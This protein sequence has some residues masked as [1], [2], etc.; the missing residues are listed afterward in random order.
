MLKLETLPKPLSVAGRK[1]ACLWNLCPF[2]CG[3]SHVTV[4][5]S[6]SQTACFSWATEDLSGQDRGE[7]SWPRGKSWPLCQYKTQMGIWDSFSQVFLLLS[8]GV[9]LGL[10]LV[11]AWQWLF[12][13][14]LTRSASITKC[15][16]MKTQGEGQVRCTV[17]LEN[18]LHLYLYAA[19]CP[20]GLH[21]SPHQT[22]FPEFLF[23]PMCPQGLCGLTEVSKVH[24]VLC[25]C[26]RVLPALSLRSNAAQSLGACGCVGG[27]RDPQL[28]F[29]SWPLLPK[30]AMLAPCKRRK[31]LDKTN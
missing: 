9:C 5:S 11:F 31:L 12:Y 14:V 22:L 27:A 17:P 8:L 6:A 2:F 4:M 28:C 7:T 10:E 13:F 15:R 30:Q 16:W 19:T 23:T 3:G 24:C 18:P 25:Q 21:L 1:L 29:S 20:I 26:P